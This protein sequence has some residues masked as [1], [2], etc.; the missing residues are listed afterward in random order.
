MTLLQVSADVWI[1]P[2]DITSIVAVCP[3]LPQPPYLV[4]TL[5]AGPVYLSMSIAQFLDKV[6]HFINL[7]AL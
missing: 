4:V 3:D 5:G 1:N 2:L 6:R 7:E